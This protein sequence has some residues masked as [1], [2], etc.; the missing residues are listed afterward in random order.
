MQAIDNQTTV[1][2]RLKKLVK[3]S[4]ASSFRLRDLPDLHLFQVYQ[5]FRGGSS[6]RDCAEYLRK[7]GHL[8]N[9]S[10]ESAVKLTGKLK[11]RISPL[12][13]TPPPPP[14]KAKLPPIKAAIASNDLERVSEL[15]EMYSDCIRSELE[16]ARDGAPLSPN[17]SKHSNGLSSLIRAKLDLLSRAPKKTGD[18]VDPELAG[19]LQKA[20]GTLPDK[21][22]RVAQL[23][24][25][26]VQEMEN[27][28]ML[29]EEDENGSF[30]EV[31]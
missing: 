23:A 25:A 11:Q 10:I 31:K 16:A 22:R 15:I 4:S 20:I 27:D 6:L 1:T 2:R 29:C 18:R 30:V 3:E 5:M 24:A 19:K 7:N 28:C 17:V 13:I 9:S 21:G 26:L 14:D 12:L 8:K